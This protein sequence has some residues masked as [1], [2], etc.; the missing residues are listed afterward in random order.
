MV[1]RLIKNLLNIV[2]G[3]EHFR[4]N[5]EKLTFVSVISFIIVNLLLLTIGKLL[6]NSCLCKVITVC[7]PVTSIWSLLGTAIVLRMVLG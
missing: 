3:D 7:K 4:N 6:W 2:V 5:E 1:D